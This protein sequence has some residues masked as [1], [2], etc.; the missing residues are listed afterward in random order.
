[1]TERESMTACEISVKSSPK[2]DAEG[3]RIAICACGGYRSSP[4]S[5]P[6]V[7]KRGAEH[8]AAKAAGRA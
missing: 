5:E 3:L 8:V 4:A 7:R 1:M 2:M 6:T